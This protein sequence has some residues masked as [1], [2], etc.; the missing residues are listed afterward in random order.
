MK[1]Q[2]LRFKQLLVKCGAPYCRS[3]DDRGECTGEIL[4]VDY[5]D[6]IGLEQYRRTD[7]KWEYVRGHCCVSNGERG[8]SVGLIPYKDFTG[9]IIREL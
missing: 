5:K 3:R 2:P 4:A 6:K 9:S 1:N 8:E 7:G